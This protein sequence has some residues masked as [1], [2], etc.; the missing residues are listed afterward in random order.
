MKQEL[1]FRGRKYI[2]P[3][4]FDSL[5]E[6]GKNYKSV[7]TR[8]S[9]MK[10]R[11]SKTPE[12]EKK[13]QEVMRNYEENKQIGLRR[14]SDEEIS[15]GFCLPQCSIVKFT[16]KSRIAFDCNA[17][18]NGIGSLNDHIL[19]D[20]KLQNDTIDV[21]TRFRRCA[22]AVIWDLSEIYLNVYLSLRD[23][24]VGSSEMGKHMNGREQSLEDPMNLCFIIRDS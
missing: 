18:C 19:I 1:E 21:L 14:V 15:N 17:K 9:E 20:P 5:P 24:S 10:Q 2:A 8:T 13:Y 3:K 7:F 16:T 4:F 22:C 23:S 11:L 12:I 6:T